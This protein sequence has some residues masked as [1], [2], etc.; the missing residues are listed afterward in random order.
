MAEHEH[1][2]IHP[3]APRLR[4]GPKKPH[5]GPT[6][7]HYHEHHSQTVGE[8]SDKW[9][10]KVSTYKCFTVPFSWTF[11]ITFHETCICFL[12]SKEQ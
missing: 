5:V 1:A 6:R 3:V 7:D 2:P 9:W 10:E 12:L 11:R 8:Q 4:N